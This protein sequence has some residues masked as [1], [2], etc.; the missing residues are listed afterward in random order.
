VQVIVIVEGNH[1]QSI[2]WCRFQWLE[3]TPNPD[4]KDATL[5]DN[6]S[7]MVQDRHTYKL[8]Q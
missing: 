1:T 6:I 4:F 8:L 2:E 3:F 7:E 5:V